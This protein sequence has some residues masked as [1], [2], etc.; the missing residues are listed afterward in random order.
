MRASLFIEKEHYD[1]QNTEPVHLSRFL[2]KTPR[3]SRRARPRPRLTLS[4]LT[5]PRLLDD[6]KTETAKGI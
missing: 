3:P 4:A 2:L 1:Y 5:A 6:F